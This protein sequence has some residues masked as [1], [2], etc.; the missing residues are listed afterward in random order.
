MV[1]EKSLWQYLKAH[2]E[3]TR[4]IE[5]I[6]NTA[7]PDESSNLPPLTLETRS[8]L[9][10]C[11]AFVQEFILDELTRYSVKKSSPTVHTRTYI[12]TALNLNSSIERTKI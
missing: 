6:V 4:I 12:Y 3:A 7:E 8:D 1:S 11:T 10:E 2:C 9:S 5:W